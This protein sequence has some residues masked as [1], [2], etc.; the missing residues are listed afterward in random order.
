MPY[1]GFCE[2]KPKTTIRFSKAFMAT[3]QAHYASDVSDCKK[4]VLKLQ[5]GETVESLYINA[6]G[7]YRRM[8]GTVERAI[9]WLQENIEGQFYIKEIDGQEDKVLVGFEDDDEAFFFG[10]AFS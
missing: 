5:E 8:S 6:G 3:N 7:F 1:K 2:E 10:I 4:V 9:G